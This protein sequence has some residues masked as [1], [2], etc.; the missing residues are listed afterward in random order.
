[1]KYKKI[2]KN[3]YSYY[4][5]A[6]SYK[7]RR[8]PIYGKTVAEVDRKT[9]EW[10][11]EIDAADLDGV[12]FETVADKYLAHKEPDLSPNSVCGYRTAVQ[13]TIDYFGEEYVAKI[14]PQ[15]C[16][17][18][19]QLFAAQGYS[20][21]VITNTKIV[22]KGIFDLAFIDGIIN[23]NPCAA[24]PVVKGKPPKKRKAAGSDA[25]ATIEQTK[26]ENDF[27]RMA[28]FMLYTGCRRG[29]AAALQYKHIDRERKC[30]HICQAVAYLDTRKPVLK[31]P[32]TESGFRDVD[33]Y[34]NVLEIIGDGPPDAFVFFPD[35]LPTKTHLE[36][37]LKAY[38]VKYDIDATSHQLRHSYASMLHSFGISAKDAQHRLGHSSIAVTED[39]YTELESAYDES[40][41]NIINAQVVE[42]V[43]K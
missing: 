41:R 31:T 9:E 10:R 25:A 17:Q 11:R 19:L 8:K 16:Y 4:Y 26:L 37:G 43:K 38:F 3:G 18:F 32:K 39:I 28:Y 5:H 1:M 40:L 12:L 7:G 35:G 30:A 34:D 29:E 36:S 20:Q 6:P 21:K 13:R 24:L 2:L 33:L 27:S 42:R 14:T 22:L 23:T 15:Q